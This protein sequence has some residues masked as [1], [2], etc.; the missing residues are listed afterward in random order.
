MRYY[1]KEVSRCVECPYYCDE[2]EFC[3]HPAWEKTHVVD[4]YRDGVYIEGFTL[5]KD[6][7][8]PDTAS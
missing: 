4:I 2:G 8:L 3:H 1:V 6:C 5:P 7:P